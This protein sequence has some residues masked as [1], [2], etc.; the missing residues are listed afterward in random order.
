MGQNST[1]RCSAK[2]RD[3]QIVLNQKY[4]V[5]RFALVY[6]DAG[7]SLPGNAISYM[8]Y[9]IFCKKPVFQFLL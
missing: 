7:N 3:K 9:D 5:R 1:I 8:E 4:L 2:R 6:I